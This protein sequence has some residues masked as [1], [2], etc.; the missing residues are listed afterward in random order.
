M[1][2][3][4]AALDAYLSASESAIK[5]SDTEFALKICK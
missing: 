5:A 1:E 2:H 4:D 3:D